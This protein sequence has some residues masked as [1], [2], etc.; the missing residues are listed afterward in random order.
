V[1]EPVVSGGNLLG[2]WTRTASRGG[3][4]ELQAYYDRTAR[5]VSSRAAATVDTADLS[6]QYRLT[7]WGAHDITLG[8]GYRVANDRFTP[9]PGTAFLTPA[10]RRQA[11]TNAYVQDEIRLGETVKLTLGVKFEDNSYTGLES[12]PSGRLTWQPT[13][14]TMVWGAVSRAVRIPSRYDRDLQNGVLLAGGADFG[15]ERLTAYEIGY[16]GRPAS[17]MALSVSA[18][19]NV[20]DDLRTVESTPVTVF[21]LVV[22]NGMEGSTYGVEAWADFAVSSRWRISAGASTLHK[23]LRLKPGSRDV[24]GIAYAGNDPDYQAQLRTSVDL[25]RTLQFDAGLRAVAELA[26]PAVPGYVE[27]DARIAWRVS[28]ATEVSVSGGNLLNDHHLEFVNGAIPRREVRRT[29][30]VALRRVF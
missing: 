28:D 25:T 19:Y 20:Y 30:F 21:P 29:V 12:M 7:P 4:F 5:T 17:F 22:R 6:L 9:G 10:R 18:F 11:W 16:R 27:A 3:V 15:S 2:R 14:R 23:D 13:D 8:G 1:V 26:N 24:F